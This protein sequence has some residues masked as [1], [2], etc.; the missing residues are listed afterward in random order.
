M[1]RLDDKPNYF[2]IGSIV[3]FGFSL[4]LL[5]Y[6]FKAQIAE[7]TL[8]EWSDISNI[9]L[10]ITTTLTLIVVGLTYQENKK[11]DKYLRTLNMI[12]RFTG[13]SNIQKHLNDLIN[14][15][16]AYVLIAISN[17]VDPI[18]AEKMD[19]V[20]SY[21]EELGMYEAKGLLD[22][23]LIYNFFMISVPKLYERYAPVINKMRS[24]EASPEIFEYFE[25]LNNK[26]V[27]RR[28]IGK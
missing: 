27:S 26:I 21:F 11:Q 17:Q 8:N 3:F 22:W 14:L 28:K 9:G 20:F 19:T 5:F 23:D 24:E 16:T 1:P 2:V 18:L 10:F 6:V 7:I 13:V 12:S 25:K 15:H 4:F